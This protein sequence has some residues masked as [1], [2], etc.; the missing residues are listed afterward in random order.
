[1]KLT[2]E[3]INGKWHVN[4]KTLNELTPNEKNAL[5]QFIKNYEYGNN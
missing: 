1:M 5:D 2:I 4:G 3:V